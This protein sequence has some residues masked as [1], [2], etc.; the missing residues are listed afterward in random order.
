MND[1]K[2][3]RSRMPVESVL[4]HLA[5]VRGED[6]IVITNQSMIGRKISGLEDLKEIHRNM[7]DAVYRHGGII[8]DIFF[9]PHR[10]DG[11]CDCRKPK[12]GLILQAA[13]DFDIELG[14]SWMVG[15]GIRDV[16]AGKRAGTAGPE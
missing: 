9:C 1:M 2:N 16:E 8:R 4:Q 5:Q 12:P 14:A 11:N 7:S 15:D 10:P 13:E 3:S 6:Q